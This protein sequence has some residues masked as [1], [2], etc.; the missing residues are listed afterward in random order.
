MHHLS[1]HMRTWMHTHTHTPEC[2]QH[3]HPPTTER[4]HESIDVNH[5]GMQGLSRNPGKD[6]RDNNL[7]PDSGDTVANNCTGHDGARGSTRNGITQYVTR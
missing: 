1:T 7:K 2:N 6:S 5:R 3:A 4:W